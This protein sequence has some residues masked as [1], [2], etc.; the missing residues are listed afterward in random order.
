MHNRVLVLAVFIVASCG[1]AYELIAGALSSYLLGDSIL[2]FS[3]I[4]GCY[5]FAM[6]LGAHLS[7]FVADDLLIERFIDVELLIALLGGVSATLLFLVFAYSGSSF[8]GVLYVVVF[9]I[10][11]MVGME[12]PLV[13][14]VLHSRQ[15]A[16]KDIVSRVLTF[17]YLGALA[18]SLLFP[19]VLAPKLGLARTAFLFGLMNSLVAW[20]M[21]GL[22]KSELRHPPRVRL[23]ASMVVC[24]MLLGLAFS[25]RLMQWTERGLYGDEVIHAQTTAYQR[26]VV[27]R[28]KDD[29]RLHLNGNL[30]FSSRDEYRYHE[31]LV[32][33]IMQNLPGAR[34]VLVLGGG[35][36]L[37]V[38]ELLKYQ[39]I[40]NI[41]LVD[42]D[43]QMTQLFSTSSALVALNENALKNARVTVVNADAMQWLEGQNQIFDAAIVDFP[44]PSNFSL[45]KLY[46]VP[47]Y[48]LLA[49]HITARG[50]VA[51][52][53]T[54][55]FFAPNAFWSINATL[56]ESGLKTWPY[57]AYVPSFGEWGF[58]A[59]S[60]QGQL[61]VP[62][63]YSVPTRYLDERNSAALFDFPKDMA[64]RK[65]EP[66]FL[67]SQPLVRYFEQDWRAAVR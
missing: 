7:R 41:T 46:S 27:T 47:F 48:R 19:L 44:D 17:D 8:R 43:P 59:A 4:I 60:A 12:I 22:F 14:R 40:E 23:K 3:S 55:P 61:S 6:G 67:N 2:Q 21:V 35:D 29:L 53:S 36:G 49:K 24:L 65:V 42:L 39:S 30:Q 34:R 64:E 51:I 16:F 28:W 5:L 45:G 18:V 9:L 25:D 13:M 57:H 56:R 54:S 10:G 50:F 37:A 52:Q 20:W 62:K 33:P 15:T 31:S 38:R 1:L 26:I 66:N 58:I 11:A 32:H 63:T